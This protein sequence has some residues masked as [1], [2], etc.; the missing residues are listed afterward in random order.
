MLLIY[1]FFSPGAIGE[2]Y[3]IF[4]VKVYKTVPDL[5][6]KNAMPCTS[7]KFVDRDFTEETK[8]VYIVYSYNH[9]I[10]N[11]NYNDIANEVIENILTTDG[12]SAA[13]SQTGPSRRRKRQIQHNCKVNEMRVNKDNI[14][15][16]MVGSVSQ[17][18]EVVVPLSYNAGI[19][20]GA[21]DTSLIPDGSPSNHAPFVYLLI[22]QKKFRDLHGYS[23]QRCCAPVKYGPLTVFS[24]SDGSHQINTIDNMIVKQ[25]QCL[26]IIV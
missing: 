8:P 26:D 16:K 18:F 7:I 13:V 6:S 21:C 17:D 24:T 5:D 19:C 22:E 10:E 25:C 9:E 2:R 14:Y 11:I 20:G 1:Q 15:N 4:H 3:A 12:D 23:F